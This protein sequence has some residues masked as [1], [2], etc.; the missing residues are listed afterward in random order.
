MEYQN[1]DEKIRNVGRKLIA[2]YLKFGIVCGI[3][4]PYD[5]SETEARNLAHLIIITA[6][7]IITFGSDKYFPVLEKM[8]NEL[9]SLK[10]EDGL[11]KMREKIG[12]DNCNGVIGHA[13]INEAFIYLYKITKN[14]KYL[15]MAYEISNK[16]S[17]QRNIGLWGRPGMGN[18]EQAIDFTFNHQ[19]WYAATLAELN[20][21]TKDRDFEE[22]LNIFMQNL[23]GNLCI[24]H[25]GKIA[26]SIYRRL[27][28]VSNMK[29]VVKKALNNFNE[30]NLKP[31]FAYKEEGYHMFNMMAFARIYNFFPKHYFFETKKFKKAIDYINNDLFLEGL[32]DKNIEL[33][34][35]FHNKIENPNEKNINIYGYPYNVPGFEILYSSV[36]FQGMINSDIVD[37]C[38]K[39]QFELT[40]NENEGIFGSKCHDKNTINYRVYEYYRYLEIVK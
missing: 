11:Y 38:I 36:I 21:Y 28:A 37:E 22:Q 17:F 34:L 20:Y 39:Q 7:E 33:D 32:L 9:C 19:L 2:D 10:N 8:G 1:F 24:M 35:S 25:D 27:T 14:N 16:H 18:S 29:Y 31:S 40:F 26:H 6:I 15:K 30:K 5:D 4:G 13:W 23:K 3:N 12:K